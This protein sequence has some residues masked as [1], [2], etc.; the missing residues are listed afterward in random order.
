MRRS[1][2][3][4]G[5]INRQLKNGLLIKIQD[6]M[7]LLKPS[8]KDMARKETNRLLNRKENSWLFSKFNSTFMNVPGIDTL[9]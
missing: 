3:K 4:T 2:D 7:H 6:F 9:N 8:G 5:Q 1:F